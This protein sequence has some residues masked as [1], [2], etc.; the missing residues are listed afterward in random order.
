MKEFMLGLLTAML[1]PKPKGKRN[2]RVIGFSNLF[3]LIKK[4]NKG[5]VKINE[6]A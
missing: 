2:S 1:R 4:Y 3:I 5:C 6:A